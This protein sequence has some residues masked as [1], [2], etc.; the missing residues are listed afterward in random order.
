MKTPPSPIEKLAWEITRVVSPWIRVM[1][2]M[3]TWHKEKLAN[4]SLE[5]IHF[6]TENVEEHLVVLKV[7]NGVDLMEL[8]VLLEGL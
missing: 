3:F 1:M 6:W 7:V 5:E 4:A 8:R 2:V